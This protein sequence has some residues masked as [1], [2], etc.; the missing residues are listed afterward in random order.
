MLEFIP[1]TQAPANGIR[2]F[3][4]PG[5]GEQISDSL[6]F[7]HACV[8]PPNASIIHVGGQAGITDEGTVPTDLGDEIREAFSHIE[9]SLRSAG[10]TGT[11]AEVTTYHANT[12]E[13]FGMILHQILIEHVGEN[14]PLFTG[15]DVF[16][17]LRPDLHLEIEVEAFLPKAA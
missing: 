3:N 10:L 11:S 15:V 13:S 12:D 14:R 7:T 8:I 1:P 6:K 4:W 16:K 9:L 5:S 17:L 2:F